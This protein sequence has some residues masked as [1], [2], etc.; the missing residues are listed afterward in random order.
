MDG[1]GIVS[2]VDDSAQAARAAVLG[3]AGTW[4]RSS[5]GAGW[6]GL[7]VSVAAGGGS[8][9]TG[10]ALPNPLNPNAARLVGRIYE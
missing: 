3:A 9:G 5:L 10:W 6:W 7:T 2:W 1:L 8:I 4:R